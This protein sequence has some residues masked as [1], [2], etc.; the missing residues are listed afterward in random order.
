MEHIENTIQHRNNKQLPSFA[1]GKNVAFRKVFY[2]I[3]KLLYDIGHEAK[4]DFTSKDESISNIQEVLHTLKR[5][6]KPC[7]RSRFYAV[8]E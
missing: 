7:E 5:S 6:F 3:R 4:N 1:C 2:F 8:I